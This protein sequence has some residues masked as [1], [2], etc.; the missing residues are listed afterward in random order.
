MNT[1]I[2]IVIPVYNESEVIRNT[3]EKLTLTGSEELIIVD[4]GSTDNTLSI[5]RE[6][7]EKVFVHE[8]GRARV[9]NYGAE[10]AAG[11]ILL[12][13]HA[14]CVL[15]PG[16]FNLIRR[17][18]DTDAVSAGAFTLGIDHPDFRFRVIEFG[19]NLRSRVSS[20]V[21]GDQG[22]FM[23]KEVF[24]RLGGYADIPLMEDIEM[25]GR[26]KKAGRIALVGTPILASPRRW[27]A[28]GAMYTTFR[29]WFIAFSYKFLKISPE[30]LIKHY[31]AV[32]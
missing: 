11:D 14:D 7:S 17:T 3:L 22:I 16:G 27:L 30:T 21:Y 2:S 6:F 5:A 25:S 15:P 24:Q 19:A 13:L 23:R 10:K 32:R 9:M 20:I 4:G 18:L 28:E 29:D 31:R 26:L 8:T 12:F 1:K